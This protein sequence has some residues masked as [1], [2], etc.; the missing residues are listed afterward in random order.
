MNERLRAKLA[1][2]LGSAVTRAQQVSGGDI[3]EAYDVALADGRRVLVKTH[4]RS[5]EGMYAA[6]AHGLQTLARARALRIPEVL[7]HAEGDAAGQAF[8]AIEYIAS[9]ARGPRFDEELGRGLAAL[10]RSGL[11]SFGLE[12]DNYIAILPQSNT[13]CASWSELYAEHRLR[14]QLKLAVERGRASAV[15]RSGLEQLCAKLPALVGPEEPPARLHGDLWGGNLLVDDRGAPCLIDPAVYGGHREIDLAMMHLFG[16]F[17]ER[18]F[19]AYHEAFPLADGHEER[20][21]LYQL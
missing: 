8:L 11:P 10:H 3:N 17:S 18:T 1:A 12:R 2:A 5:P 4:P 19:A 15:M 6:E 13:R 7:A 14:A 20:V 21:P 9:R 16:G